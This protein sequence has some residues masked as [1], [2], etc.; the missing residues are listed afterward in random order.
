MTFDSTLRESRTIK[1]VIEIE[2]LMEGARSVAA[3][4]FDI[5]F[6]KL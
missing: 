3:E 2:T 5:E 4:L 6:G 1:I